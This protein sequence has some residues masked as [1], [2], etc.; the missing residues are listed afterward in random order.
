M[1]H[2]ACMVESKDGDEEQDYDPTQEN[3]IFLYQ[4]TSGA[5]PKSYGFHAAR[6]AGLDREI[7]SRGYQRAKEMERKMA[8][9][10]LFRDL[11]QP[12][13]SIL[14]KGIEPNWSCLA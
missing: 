14:A 5:C 3:I 10:Q 4:F 8:S 11:F 9:V 7:I 1:G 2:M 6:L 12:G 13:R